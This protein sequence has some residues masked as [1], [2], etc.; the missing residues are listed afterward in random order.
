MSIVI[1]PNL[2]PVAVQGA[3][4]AGIVLQPG[5]VIGAQV[6]QIL[7]NDQ[8]R[9]SIGGQPL[10]VTSQVPLQAGQTLQL[11]VSQ[12]ANGIGLAIV[13]QQGGAAASQSPAGATAT[14]DT[15]TLAPD[16][17]AGIAAL[18]RQRPPR[19]TVNSV[20]WRCLRCR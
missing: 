4:S 5:S 9:I 6:L 1:A 8:V 12:T 11:Q 17:A 15:V 19:R 16:A 13:N 14:L 7:G 2:P 20:R 18:Q 3:T 10:D